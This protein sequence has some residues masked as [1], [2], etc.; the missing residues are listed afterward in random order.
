MK[1]LGKKSLNGNIADCEYCDIKHT[2]RVCS[3]R[4]NADRVEVAINSGGNLFEEEITT[5]NN[6]TRD[7]LHILIIESYE[8]GREDER[9]N[10][11]RVFNFN[12]SLTRAYKLGRKHQIDGTI[13]SRE[14]I[15]EEVQYGNKDVG[16]I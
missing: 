7:R 12:P 4:C 14:A 9:N 16:G 8:Y 11:P 13:L 5:I 15:L 3:G 1:E 6:T 10:L 2:F